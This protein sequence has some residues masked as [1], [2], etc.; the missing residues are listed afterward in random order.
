MVSLELVISLRS[1]GQ[2]PGVLLLISRSVGFLETQSQGEC[3]PAVS[4]ECPIK[5]SLV[6]SA[7]LT[8]GKGEGAPGCCRRM[9]HR[10]QLP[11][12]CACLRLEGGQEL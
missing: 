11:A 4:S 5:G 6:G 8:L 1:Q 7:I 9:K 10:N 2:A 3:F 12:Y